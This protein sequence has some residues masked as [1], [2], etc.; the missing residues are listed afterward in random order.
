MLCRKLL[1]LIGTANVWSRI[2][3]LQMLLNTLTLFRRQYV[4]FE[5]GKQEFKV[6]REAY[7]AGNFAK[8]ASIS[9]VRTTDNI[10]P[11][12]ALPKKVKTP[13]V[14][15]SDSATNSA[16]LEMLYGKVEYPDFCRIVEILSTSDA[17]DLLEIVYGKVEFDTYVNVVRVIDRIKEQIPCKEIF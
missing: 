6:A 8:L 3:K 15:K 1:I 14:N 4:D 17:N 13:T 2:S 11:V 12:T 10:A 16:I 5:A 9:N 7:K